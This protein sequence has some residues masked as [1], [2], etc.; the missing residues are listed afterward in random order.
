MW[1]LAHEE[2][3]F[4]VTSLSCQSTPTTDQWS[5][6]IYLA[7]EAGFDGTQCR[8]IGL[9]Y[10]RSRPIG[11]VEPGILFPNIDGKVLNE[12]MKIRV[13]GR[14]SFR[15]L[16]AG[17]YIQS[18]TELA[19][20]YNAAQFW[21]RGDRDVLPRSI[22]VNRLIKPFYIFYS[23]SPV[24]GTQS[25]IEMVQIQLSCAYHDSI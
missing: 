1:S 8:Y 9:L 13:M 3:R 7:F 11:R 6:L 5:K 20:P 17:F 21:L 14:H 10:P 23:E 24:A 22:D 18:R 25:K 19:S 12:A 15:W 2:K 4:V 16:P